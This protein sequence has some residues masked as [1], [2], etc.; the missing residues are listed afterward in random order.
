[1]V[2]IV[3]GRVRTENLIDSIL[4]ATAR[5]RGKMA[6]TFLVTGKLA[7]NVLS[8]DATGRGKMADGFIVAG[9]VAAEA[10]SDDKLDSFFQGEMLTTVPETGLWVTY[11]TPYT[12]TPT[13]MAVPGPGNT[14]ARV[15][16]VGVDSFEW[17]GAAGP[18]PGTASW[19]AWGHR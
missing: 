13:V 4:P 18:G 12:A 14:W 5:G 8:A 3:D 7:D 2:K 1:M 19:F 17:Q 11:P 15:R 10:I 16:Q 9:E 6:D